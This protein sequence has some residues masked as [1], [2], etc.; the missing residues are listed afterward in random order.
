MVVVSAQAHTIEPLH[1]SRSQRIKFCSTF[2][3]SGSTAMTF[4][5][6]SRGL[7]AFSCISVADST[8]SGQCEVLLHTAWIGR[9][10]SQPRARE[11]FYVAFFD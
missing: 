5:T 3:T 6:P 1:Q 4:T 10:S 7:E 2:A 9:S 11:H 8:D